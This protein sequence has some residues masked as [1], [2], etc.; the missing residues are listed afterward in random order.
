M[1]TRSRAATAWSGD[2]S[3]FQPVAVKEEPVELPT[4]ADDGEGSSSEPFSAEEQRVS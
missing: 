1:L 4:L 2:S 3:G